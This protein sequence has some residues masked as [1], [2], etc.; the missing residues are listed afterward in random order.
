MLESQFRIPTFYGAQNAQLPEPDKGRCDFSDPF[1]KILVRDEDGLRVLLMSGDIAPK[2]APDILIERR[3][4]G[5]AMFLHPVG[6]SEPS[7][8]VYFLDDG[9][10]YVIPETGLGPTPAIEVHDDPEACLELDQL[11]ED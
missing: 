11:A 1:A 9:R 5:W 6:N 3:P 7:G 8:Y 10:S 4:H 2:D